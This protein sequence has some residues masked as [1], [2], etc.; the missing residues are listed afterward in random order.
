[1]RKIFG[2]DRLTF[3]E[4][5]KTWSCSRKSQ[6]EEGREASSMKKLTVRRKRAE[7]ATCQLYGLSD[8]LRR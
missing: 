2:P 3:K 8:C 7:G 4:R 1:M 5:S 6:N